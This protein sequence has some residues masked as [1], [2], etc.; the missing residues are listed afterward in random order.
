M[1]STIIH[2]DHPPSPLPPTRPRCPLFPPP[3]SDKTAPFSRPPR[4][5]IVPQTTG[6]ASEP[7]KE[8]DNHSQNAVDTVVRTSDFVAGRVE[9]EFGIEGGL[10]CGTESEKKSG[11]G[12]TVEELPN[13]SVHDVASGNR[14]IIPE[15]TR[16]KTVPSLVASG[17]GEARIDASSGGV[18]SGKADS[19]GWEM[20]PRITV[21][22]KAAR[23]AVM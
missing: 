5:P 12:V 21:D 18:V 2:R 20:G 6:A 13:D 7:S 14:I 3:F 8:R 1:C 23:A 16:D 9:D 11:S 17:W 22:S 19:G 15:I 4:E 10:K